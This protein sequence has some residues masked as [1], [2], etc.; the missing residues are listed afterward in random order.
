MTAIKII[1]QGS[2]GVVFQGK[3]RDSGEIVAVKKVLQDP[4][5]KNRELKIMRLLKKH[6]N[7]VELKACFYTREDKNDLYLNIVMDYI[8]DS[9]SHVLRT[10]S[11]AHQFLPNII[12]KLY[13]YQMLRS[14]LYIH[15]LG[16]CHRDIKPQNI[17]VDPETHVVMLCDF[18][19]AKMLTPGE[20]N[21]AYICSRYY[22]APELIF[23]AT[24]Y[25]VAID[26]WSIG[27]VFAEMMLG[28]P[29]FPGDSSVDQLVEIIKILGTPTKEEIY[30]MNPSYEENRFPNLSSQA[31]IKVFKRPIPDD[32]LDLLSKMF[33][34]VPSQRITA[35][36]AL[37]HP[38]FDELRSAGLMLP[39]GTPVPPLFNFNPVGIYIFFYLFIFQLEIRV[40]PAVFEKLIPP[41]GR[42]SSNWPISAVVGR[43]V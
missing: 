26:I 7:V 15:A 23:G 36:D 9:L 37:C 27:C 31:W 38:Y 42:S 14:L 13:I 43:D 33:I 2:F 20:P 28:R 11:K 3:L 41:H 29:I 35:I 30:A 17:L 39:N 6:P 16:V 25:T 34:Y 21:V 22:R 18:G 1:G 24:Q 19:S 8:P 32:A 4:R 40:K 5:Y 12:V 10:Y